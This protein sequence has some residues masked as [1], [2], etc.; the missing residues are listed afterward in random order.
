MFVAFSLTNYIKHQ[1]DDTVKVKSVHFDIPNDD[2]KKLV[3]ARLENVVVSQVRSVQDDAD[4]LI[5]DVEDVENEKFVSPASGKSRSRPHSSDGSPLTKK[6]NSM[7]S[8][9]DPQTAPT[10][11]VVKMGKSAGDGDP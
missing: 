10:K 3:E 11:L 2:A 9:L 1:N 6:R 8:S 4:V 7:I 5:L